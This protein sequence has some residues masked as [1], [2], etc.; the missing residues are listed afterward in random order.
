MYFISTPSNECFEFVIYSIVSFVVSYMNFHSR[1]LYPYWSQFRCTS[2]SFVNV[3]GGS[4]CFSRTNPVLLILAKVPQSSR[5]TSTTSYFG[6]NQNENQRIT[7][8]TFLYLRPSLFCI[9]DAISWNGR[10]LLQF[11]RIIWN[12]IL[13][14]YLRAVGRSLVSFKGAF[15]GRN[16]AGRSKV[17]NFSSIFGSFRWYSTCD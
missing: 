6:D 1:V 9:W 17:F 5:R 3:I 10:S 4:E 15:G 13:E 12:M 16:G 8:P 2:W 14:K 11:H 7:L